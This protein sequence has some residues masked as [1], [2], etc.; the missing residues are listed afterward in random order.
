MEAPPAR[1]QNVRATP[2]TQRVRVQWDA[3]PTASENPDTNVY[4]VQWKESAAS[5][6]WRE[7]KVRGSQTAMTITGLRP[8]TGYTVRVI[9]TRHKAPDGPPSAEARATT[10]GFSYRVKGT[11]PAQ[12]TGVNL[13]GATVT[14]ELQGAEWRHYWAAAPL[15]AVRPR[16]RRSGGAG[17]AG[18][19]S[20][21]RGSS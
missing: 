11:D 3:V 14:V 2:G 7:R 13:N 1:V 19:A 10:P 16:H 8:G 4:R 12:L 18:L 15:Q 17:G 5:G 20:P 21:R 9:A 6:G